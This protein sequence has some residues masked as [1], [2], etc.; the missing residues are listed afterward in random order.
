MLQS[1]RL[2]VAA[3][4]TRS[5]TAAAQR[6]HATQSGVSQHVRNLEQRHGVRLFVREGSGMQPT[7]AAH[8]FYG[9]CVAALRAV[10]EGEAAL[11]THAGGISG[12]A[13]VGLMPTVTAA[14]LAPALIDFRQ[15]HPNAHVRIVEGFSGALTATTLAGELDFAVVPAMAPVA[16]LRIRGFLEMEEMFVSRDTGSPATPEPLALAEMGPLK[17]ILPEAGNVRASTIR[18]FVATRGVTIAEEIEID[19]MMAALDLI[20]RSDWCAILPA[21][22]MASRP[23]RQGLQV[24]PIAPPLALELVMVEPARRPASTVA[25]AFHDCLLRAC[26]T[27]LAIRPG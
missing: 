1:L 22:M 14:A 4:E 8:A 26:R 6:E 17:L 19:S 7:E 21:L 24:R 2:F 13:V 10:E 5:F 23:R 11:R 3:Y 18:T 12:V 20:A 25:M 9:H 15:R 16:G 27:L